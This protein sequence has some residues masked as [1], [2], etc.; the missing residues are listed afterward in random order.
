M[1]PCH[2]VAM[3]GGQDTVALSVQ[4]IQLRATLV[5]RLFQYINITWPASRVMILIIVDQ[6]FEL[7]IY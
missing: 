5:I 4:N 7:R 2:W 6:I 3:N 1:M